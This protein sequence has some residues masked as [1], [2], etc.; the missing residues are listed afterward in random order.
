MT[1]HK[2]SIRFIHLDDSSEY[3]YPRYTIA[4]IRTPELVYFAVSK[5]N[6][7]DTYSKKFGRELTTKRLTEFM[8][9]GINSDNYCGVVTK[10]ELFI[11]SDLQNILS[12][13]FQIHVSV[14]DLKHRI[15]G[16]CIL[17]RLF[18]LQ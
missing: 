12:D 18:D 15:I 9:S 4:Y 11:N 14:M 5:P 7:A 8:T 17:D 3:T 1:Q 2:Q 13:Q 16:N 10:K 6:D